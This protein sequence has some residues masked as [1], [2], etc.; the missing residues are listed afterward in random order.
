MDLRQLTEKLAVS[1][2]ISPADLQALA[3][4]GF[5][6]LIDNR[7]DSEVGPSDDSVAMRAAAQAAG[8][9]FHYIP[10]D[11][12]VVTPDMVQSFADATASGAPALAYCRSGNRSSILW[13]L[14]QARNLSE[15][16]IL[17]RASQAG[18]DLSQ[19]QPLIASLARSG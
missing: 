15:E 1:A 13:A 6:L 8:L 16:E 11:P 9:E 7:P 5:K 17:A 18:Y 2:Q 10:F 4:A 19:I 3:D 12:G 14:S